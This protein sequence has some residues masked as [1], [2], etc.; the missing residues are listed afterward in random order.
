VD[1]LTDYYTQNINKAKKLLAEAGYPNGFDMTI[2]VPSNY[3]PHVDTAQVLVEQLKAIN[4]NATIQLVDWNSWLK[5]VYTDR[6]FQ[7]TVVG[8]D[9]ANMT[10]R[11][12]LERFTSGYDGNFINYN[13]A[14][15]DALFQ[16]ALAEKDDAA[17]TEIYQQMEENLTEHAANVYIQDLADLVAIR[18]NLAG[19]TFY[20]IYVMDLSKVHYVA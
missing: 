2:T 17:R 13:N 20:P 3:Q 7:S 16:K 18:N 5:D 10:A 11:A 6:S 14:D 15:Y 8:V 9:A 12:M 4:V 19:Y 1:D